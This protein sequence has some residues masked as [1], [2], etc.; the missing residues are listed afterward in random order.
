MA[1]RSG[2]LMIMYKENVSCVKE[3]RHVQRVA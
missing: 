3:G 2:A 1:M